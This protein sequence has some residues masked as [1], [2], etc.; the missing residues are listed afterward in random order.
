MIFTTYEN[1]I[2]SLRKAI[3]EQSDLISDR[4]LNALSVRGTDLSDIINGVVEDNLNI[5]NSFILFELLYDDGNDYVVVKNDDNSMASIN[6]FNLNL[7]IYGNDSYMTAQ[8]LM[9]RFRTIDCAEKLYN[10]GIHFLG[11]TNPTTI[12]EFINDTMWIRQDLTIKIEVAFK[13]DNQTQLE[14]AEIPSAI[15]AQ[16]IIK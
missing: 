16:G 14:Y 11:I 1:I 15:I 9:S 6:Y 4:V 2:I 10:S 5:D 13:I 7:H 12:N 8:K 3:I